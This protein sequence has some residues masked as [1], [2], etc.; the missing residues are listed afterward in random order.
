MNTHSTAQEALQKA[1]QIL[2]ESDGLLIT[3]GAGMG[4]DSGLPDFR[5]NEGFWK[6]YP[7]LAKAGYE[8]TKVASPRTFEID[9]ELAWGF[10]GHRLAL[11][12]ATEPNPAFAVLKAWASQYPSGYFVVTSNVD[13]QFQ[14]AGF[15]AKRIYEVHGSIHKL[16][17]T[18]GCQGETWTADDFKPELDE[19]TCKLL[20]RLPRCP[21]CR[22]IARPNI[23]MFSDWG[24]VESEAYLQRTVFG[25][26]KKRVT[27]LAI[28]EIGAG[29]TIETI[30]M[31][32]QSQGI[33]SQLIRIN[34]RE[35][36]I[37]LGV[38]GVSL[39]MTGLEAI[40]KINDI[41]S[42]QKLVDR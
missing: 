39:P 36:N 26:W 34:L 38:K 1:A 40:L 23:L 5:G 7:A 9:P 22:R 8:F 33:D 11:Y 30:R 2:R 24:W 20:N 17:C 27:R 32:S 19:S 6:A 42:D 14:K 4:V 18:S 41:L 12:R 37:P 31:V 3:A 10:Y 21:N 25:H 35:S 29:T 16:Q 13:G 28:V 15:N